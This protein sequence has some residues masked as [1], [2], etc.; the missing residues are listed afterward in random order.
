MTCFCWLSHLSLCCCFVFASALITRWPRRI[1]SGLQS[2]IFLLR[3]P[4]RFWLYLHYE[5]ILY[6]L[7]TISW[8][9]DKI[10]KSLFSMLLI[11]YRWRSIQLG[12]SQITS[13]ISV[14]LHS[15]FFGGPPDRRSDPTTTLR[16]REGPSKPRRVMALPGPVW[17]TPGSLPSFFLVFFYWEKDIVMAETSELFFKGI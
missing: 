9:I 13:R 17:K 1:D 7:I 11:S 4:K 10:S 14:A 16:N 2:W 15:V 12:T 8:F 5:C 3:R 6:V